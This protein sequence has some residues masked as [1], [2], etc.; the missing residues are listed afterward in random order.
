MLYSLFL[1]NEGDIDIYLLHKSIDDR[2]IEDLRDFIKE[3]QII[4]QV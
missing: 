3:N 4:K 1:T 2:S